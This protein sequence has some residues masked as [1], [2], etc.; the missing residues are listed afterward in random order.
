MAIIVDT[1]SFCHYPGFFGYLLGLFQYVPTGLVIGIFFWSI[2]F[3]DAFFFSLAIT[4]KFVWF[5]GLILKYFMIP[6]LI[7]LSVV[8]VPS[9]CDSYVPTFLNYISSIFFPS[10]DTT[11]V[12][13]GS[14]FP[15]IDVLQTGA[16][17]GFVLVYYYFWSYPLRWTPCIGLVMLTLVPW[18]FISSSG[19][20]GGGAV[21][22]VVASIYTG[23]ILGSVGLFISYYTYYS[24]L[25]DE[26]DQKNKKSCMARQCFHFW[27]GPSTLVSSEDTIIDEDLEPI[28]V[29][30]SLFFYK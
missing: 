19:G 15:N 28:N 8:T 18:S 10:P 29:H 11:S 22:S 27:C 25:Y 9:Q 14:A 6:F 7:P 21:W 1:L 5:G 16:Y 30:Q 3:R 4:M 23:I 17:L 2:A 12:I 26:I 13:Q 20:V 24:C